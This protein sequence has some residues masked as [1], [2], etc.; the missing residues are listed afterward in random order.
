MKKL[1]VKNN[2]LYILNEL[3]EELEVKILHV[4]GGG[5]AKRR[6]FG[7]S[8]M[9]EWLINWVPDDVKEYLNKITK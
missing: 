3:E 7:S 1:Y 8:T 4:A 5:D 6:L 2:R 9:R